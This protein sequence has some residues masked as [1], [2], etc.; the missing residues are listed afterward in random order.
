MVL[1]NDLFAFLA[2]ISGLVSGLIGTKFFEGRLTRLYFYFAYLNLGASF[3]F[4][5]GY[6]YFLVGLD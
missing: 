2:I 1:F 3:V 5:V 4:F 6:F